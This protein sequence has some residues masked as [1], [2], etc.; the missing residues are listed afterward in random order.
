MTVK[1][2]F[3]KGGVTNI[4]IKLMSKTVKG[5]ERVRIWPENV[6]S[7]SQL[8]LKEKLSYD[9]LRGVHFSGQNRTRS[10][11]LTVMFDFVT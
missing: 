1:V 2:G 8:F 5:P 10:A 4:S 3:A 11:T 6:I 7:Q 9:W